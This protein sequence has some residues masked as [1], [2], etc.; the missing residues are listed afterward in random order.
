MGNT[1]H[2]ASE[3][4]SKITLSPYPKIKSYF[5]IDDDE[6]W[7][8]SDEDDHRFFRV[9]YLAQPELVKGFQIVWDVD[10][11]LHQGECYYVLLGFY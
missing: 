5:S 6:Y 10:V 8:I 7:D 11:F 4:C 1:V 9:A 2:T 3:P